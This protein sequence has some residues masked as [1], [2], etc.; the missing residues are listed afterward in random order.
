MDTPSKLLS[1]PTPGA[2]E[3]SSVPL[4]KRGGRIVAEVN[5]WSA[6]EPVET[7]IY[8][9]DAADFPQDLVMVREAKDGRSMEVLVWGDPDRQDATLELRIPIREPEDKR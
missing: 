7:Y 9:K 1:T 5:D 6:G 8:L 3:V 2:R 4:S